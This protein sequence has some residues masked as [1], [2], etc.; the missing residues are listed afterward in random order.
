MIIE[1]SISLPGL[2]ET[3]K[4]YKTSFGKTIESFIP[5]LGI[6]DVNLHRYELI[7]PAPPCGGFIESSIFFFLDSSQFLFSM[8]AR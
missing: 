3:C 1:F 6:K 2:S 4:V 7:D 8:K 5:C